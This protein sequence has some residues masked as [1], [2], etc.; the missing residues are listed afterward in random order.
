MIET[1]KQDEF[2]LICKWPTTLDEYTRMNSV[3]SYDC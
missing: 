3:V 1:F 2:E